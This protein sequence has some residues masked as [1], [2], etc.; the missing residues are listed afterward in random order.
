MQWCSKLGLPPA[1]KICY[2]FISTG[3]ENKNIFFCQVW[4]T[5]SH[6]VCLIG[7]FSDDLPTMDIIRAGFKC[8]SCW[9]WLIYIFL[10]VFWESEAKG[11]TKCNRIESID[12]IFFSVHELYNVLILQ[13]H[14]VTKNKKNL[15]E[16]MITGCIRSCS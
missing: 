5:N 15:W 16:A 13:I 12:I 4:V 7:F 3:T 1:F 14:V 9:H 2:H 8:Q 6:S 11:I 10:S